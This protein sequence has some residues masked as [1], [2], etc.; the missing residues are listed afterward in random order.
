VWWFGILPPKT[1]GGT[2]AIGEAPSDSGPSVID[3]FARTKI[4]VIDDQAAA[5]QPSRV[6]SQR[7][8]LPK[9]RTADFHS[10]RLHLRVATGQ[11]KY[12]LAGKSLTSLGAFI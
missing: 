7:L 9:K 11:A 2:W 1:S 4:C 8:P 12:K 10:K 3:V 6:Q 5:Q